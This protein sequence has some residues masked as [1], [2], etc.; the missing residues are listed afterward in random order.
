MR[1]HCA[2]RR[3]AR[4][5][6]R[7]VP[8]KNKLLAASCA[9]FFLPLVAAF[10]LGAC[11]SEEPAAAAAQTGPTAQRTHQEPLAKACEAKVTVC[12][13]KELTLNPAL[14]AVVTGISKPFAAAGYV[15]DAELNRLVWAEF[16]EPGAARADV[17]VAWGLC[18]GDGKTCSAGTANY[19]ATG[20]TITD[21]AGKAVTRIG[22]GPPVLRKQLKFHAPDKDPTI[23]APLAQG[24]K[25]DAAASAATLAKVKAKTR[26]FVVLNAYGPQVGL[27]AAPIAKAASASGR[28]DSVEVVDF[29][30]VED[31]L[32]LLPTL[33]G[34]DAVVILAA[35]V[36]E[37]FTDKPEKPLGLA[38][39]RGVFGDALLYGKSLGDSMEAPP[40]GGPGLV[41]LAGSNTLAAD[42]FTDKS[43]IGEGLGSAAGRAVLGFNAKLT[44]GEA[45]A[46]VSSLVSSLAA[47]AHLQAAMEASKAA[48]LT[49]M[50][51]PSREKWLLAPARSAFWAGK[52]PSK[53]AITLHVSM[54]PPF[55]MTPFDPCDLPSYKANYEANKIEAAK[56]TGGHATFVCSGLQFDGPYFSCAGQDANTTADFKIAGVLRGKAKGD[57]FWL[58]VTGT[59]NTKYRQMTIVGEGTFGEPDSGGGR[60]SLPISGTAAAGPYMDQDSNCCAAGGPLLATIKS[61]PGFIEIWP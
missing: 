19:T 29:A 58:T 24:F 6:H 3:R 5:R 34:L 27:D 37:K 15:Q 40:L 12:W 61:E 7:K 39:S 23:L 52:P 49:P 33:T 44:G 13:D 43:T 31:V 2:T 51:K 20:A 54:T 9:R 55:C 60:T 32:A 38:M 26:R 48:F 1:L 8:V 25:I 41:I 10:G 56:L 45:V 21:S 36:Q 42:Y 11:G 46:A 18:K 4:Q 47:G 28:F 17:V 22:I 59:A 14:Q 35:S 30:R 57:R 53:A 16:G 50:D